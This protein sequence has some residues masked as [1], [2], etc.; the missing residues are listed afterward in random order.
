MR[1]S[2]PSVGLRDSNYR[3]SV[4]TTTFAALAPEDE[5]PFNEGP[6]RS[7]RGSAHRGMDF[8]QHFTES[9]VPYSTALH[10]TLNG[11]VYLAGPAARLH[12]NHL[13]VS[14][15]NM[16]WGDGLRCR[17][18]SLSRHCGP[19][20]GNLFAIDETLRIIQ[21]MMPRPVHRSRSFLGPASVWLVRRRRGACSIT[22][23]GR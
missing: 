11:A 13:T 15:R 21:A 8:E 22:A 2:R 7:S 12:R 20:C 18:Q 3:N 10:S 4:R 17:P 23:I 6:I 14:S 16:S 5:Y 1:R 19:F 9:Q